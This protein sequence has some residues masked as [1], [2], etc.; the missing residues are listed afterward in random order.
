MNESYLLPL[1]FLVQTKPSVHLP[2]INRGA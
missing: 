2:P 1:T